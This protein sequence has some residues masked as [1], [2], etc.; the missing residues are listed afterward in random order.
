MKSRKIVLWL[1]MLLYL[2]LFGF[3][4]VRAQSFSITPFLGGYA[5]E[6]NRN[7][8]KSIIAGFGIHFSL[9][10]K[11]K[12][13]LMYLRGDFDINYYDTNVQTCV[14]RD[15]IDTN[16]VHIGG[17]YHL[18]QY[19]HWIPYVAA[20]L[21]VIHINSDYADNFRNHPDRHYQ[22]Q[23]NYGA[24]LKY[25]ISEDISIRWDLRH[26]LTPEHMDNDISA[27]MGISYAFGKNHKKQRSTT[28]TKYLSSQIQRQSPDKGY[29][30][31]ISQP[32]T[33]K[34]K[35]IDSDN[36]G[37]L[38][39][40]DVCPKTSPAVKVDESGCPIDSDKDGV[41]DGIDRCPVTPIDVAV[42]IFGCPLD[43][44]RDGVID[45][46]DQCANT[47]YETPVDQKGCPLDQDRDG[48]PDHID[49]CPET[50]YGNLVDSKGCVVVVK[51]LKTF[52]MKIEFDYKSAEVKPKYHT[53][54]EEAAREMIRYQKAIAIIES[55]TDNIGSDAYN[56]N[57][58]NQ[59]AES[60]KN[61][62]HEHFR[63]P[64]QRMKTFG[65]GES[66]PI[67]DNNTETGRQKNR[68]VEIVISQKI[69]T[70]NKNQ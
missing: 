67:A 4:S 16:I 23:L 5:L 18:F 22:F 6:G 70:A 69:E 12:A 50:P 27:I 61:Y 66:R 41:F 52:R 65:F 35:M 48:I 31:Q 34:T 64:F 56:I 10:E 8:G 32:K 49:L 28:Q 25:S 36:D 59:R 40:Q 26:L 53:D 47:P 33:L 9:T 42:N 55:H 68:R 57:L 7:I 29:D 19:N 13:E 1:I 43:K 54:L 45:A 44:D 24:G 58:S 2:P 62:I 39:A 14:T 63:I 17:H 46:N 11:I 37:I 21:G 3:H 38:D 20:G 30:T 51:T 15:G 60:V